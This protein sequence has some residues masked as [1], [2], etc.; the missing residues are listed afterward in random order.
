MGIRSSKTS[1][2][3]EIL[4]RRIFRKLRNSI[5]TKILSIISSNFQNDPETPTPDPQRDFIY[6]EKKILL[7]RMTEVGRKGGDTLL[8]VMANDPVDFFH[9]P[10][11]SFDFCEWFTCA[12]VYYS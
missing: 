1:G 5:R 11:G 2:S 7:F 4:I 6:P 12:G 10:K 3:T 8:S 9:S